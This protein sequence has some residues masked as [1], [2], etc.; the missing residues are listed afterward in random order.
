MQDNAPIHTAIRVREWMQENSINTM[1]WPPYSPNLNPIE[2]A[3]WELKKQVQ[4]M[5]LE[6]INT[7]GELEEDWKNL[8]E[9]LNAV[10][11]AIPDSFS[12]RW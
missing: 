12:M 11:L 9:A 4:E 3:W 1:D 5:F 10:W 2:H 7:Q 8:E 6:V